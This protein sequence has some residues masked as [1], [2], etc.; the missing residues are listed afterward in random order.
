MT[1]CVTEI[2]ALVK[3]RGG[4]SL[5]EVLDHFVLSYVSVFIFSLHVTGQRQSINVWRSRP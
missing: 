5:I 4:A 3:A 1:S 2:N